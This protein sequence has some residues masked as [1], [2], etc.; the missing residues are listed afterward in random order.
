MPK[1]GLRLKVVTGTEVTFTHKNMFNVAQ[2]CGLHSFG[3]IQQFIHLFKISVRVSPE[4]CL[5]EAVSHPEPETG[6][7]Q[8]NNCA[9]LNIFAVLYSAALLS[10][11]LLYLIK[12]IILKIL[13]EVF[14]ILSEVAHL[15]CE[16]SQATQS[17]LFWCINENLLFQISTIVR[18]KS[19]IWYLY[20]GMM[21][22]HSVFD[23]LS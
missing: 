17:F 11:G 21:L 16:I 8:N 13:V 20:V 12:G 5:P 15:F 22:L 3:N 18:I 14:F 2:V 4:N 9:R 1:A 23:T 7:G 10:W 19:I 6:V